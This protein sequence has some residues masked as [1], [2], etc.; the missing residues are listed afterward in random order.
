MHTVNKS[1]WQTTNLDACLAHL[2]GE[3]LLLIEDGVYAA[4]ARSDA[5]QKLDTP[6]RDGRV[7]VLGPDLEARG[8]GT[9]Q[10]AEGIGVVDYSGFVQL[11]AE[12][13]PHQAWL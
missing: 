10:V 11:V 9:E 6:A 2:G 8:I 4:V 3:R 5:A 7:Y 1:P 12:H 13:G